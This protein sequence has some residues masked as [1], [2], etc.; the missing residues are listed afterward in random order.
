MPG[1]VVPPPASTTAYGPDPAQVYDL[2]LPGRSARGA[3]VVVV[4]GGFWRAKYD[5]ACVA[6]QAQ[7]FADNGFHVAVLEYRRADMTGGGWPGTFDDVRSAVASIA[8]DAALPRPLVAVGHSAGGH[9]VAWAASQPG[10][11]LAGVVSLA[12]CVDL[13]LTALMELGDGAAE[14]LMG[15]SPYAVPDRYAVGDPGRLVPTGA[16]VV[17]V[18]GGDDDIVPIEISE[19]YVR[20][21]ERAG[22]AVHLEIVPRCEHYGLIDPQNAAFAGVVERVRLLAK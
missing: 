8:A 13:T 11:P 18:H 15:G 22:Q 7:A 3:T 12:G 9:L 6:Q 17:L 1:S 19:S 2:R 14:A 20:L 5:R 16:E 10:T 21:A 4:H